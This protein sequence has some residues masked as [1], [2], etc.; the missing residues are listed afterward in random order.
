[1]VETVKTMNIVLSSLFGVIIFTSKAFLSPPY[2]KIA[3]IFVQVTI[4]NLAYLITGLQGSIL[5][6]L[7]SALLTASIRPA[8]ALVTFT[9]SALYGVLVGTLNRLLQVSEDGQV[10]RGRLIASS[11]MSSFIVGAI[12]AYVTISLGLIPYSEALVAAMMLLGVAQGAAGGYTCVYLWEK[13]LEKR[14]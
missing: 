8:T 5:T 3:S 12:S 9:F 4:L 2:D 1:M 13:Y 14:F 10:R 11:A 7:V 6:G